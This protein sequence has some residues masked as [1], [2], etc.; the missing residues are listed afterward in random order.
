MFRSKFP[1]ISFW[2]PVILEP[3]GVAPPCT[4]YH[5]GPKM[6]IEQSVLWFGYG[7]DNPDF[8]YRRREWF[9]CTPKCPN[10]HYGPRDPRIQRA[11]CE[12]CHLPPSTHFGNEC[13]CDSARLL[14]LHVGEHVGGG[15]NYRGLGETVKENSVNGV[16][17]S[18]GALW[19]EL[20]GR[21]PL[22]E[23]LKPT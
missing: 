20:A 2:C 15:F 10:R 17:L 5:V 3:Y 14:C 1:I 13:S 21:A 7:L 18:V 22:L 4:Y 6:E 12:T 11:K 23:T 16:S 8:D 9:S 19:G